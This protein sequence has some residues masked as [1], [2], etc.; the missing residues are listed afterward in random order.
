MASD[1]AKIRYQN[2]IF[3][4]GFWQNAES[5]ESL[6]LERLQIDVSGIPRRGNPG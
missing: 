4:N 6:S 3:A 2:T 1:D 5:N